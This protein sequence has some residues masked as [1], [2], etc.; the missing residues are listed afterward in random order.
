MTIVSSARA[1]GAAAANTPPTTPH[2]NANRAT[3]P[4]SALAVLEPLP[5]SGLAVLLAL[6]LARVAGQEPGAL[7]DAALLRIERDERA[8]DAVAHRL[9]LRGVPATL[10]RRPDVELVCRLDEL[11]R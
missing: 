2:A 1:D 7:Q 11:E 10:H 3:A 4:I 8:R 6:L 9:G 5:R